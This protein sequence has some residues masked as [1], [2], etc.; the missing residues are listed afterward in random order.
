MVAK[1]DRL[2]RSMIDFTALMGKA[3]K[4]GWA[5]VAL[6]WRWTDHAYRGGDGEHAGDV[7]AVRAQADLA[8]DKGGA[9]GEAR[10]RGASRSSAHASAAC[11]PPDTA[12]AGR[13]DSL[14]KIADDLNQAG[15]PTAHGGV[16]W[17]ADGR[18]HPEAVGIVGAASTWGSQP[19]PLAR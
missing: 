5:L 14:R 6:D 12:P 16:R 9:R 10:E 17:Y 19:L 18:L 7:R 3:Q 2:S 8:A 15:T 1:L 4:Q 11:R 13:G